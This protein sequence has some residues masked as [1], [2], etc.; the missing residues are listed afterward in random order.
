VWDYPRPPRLEASARH[1]LIRHRGEVVAETRAALRVLETSHPPTYYIPREDVRAVL[2]PRLDV[3]THCEWK[4]RAAYYDV[5]IAGET[6]RACA[7]SYPDPVPAFAE[8]RG[9]LAFYAQPFEGCFVDG[10]RVDSQTGRFYGGWI[11]ADVVGPFKGGAGTAG[12]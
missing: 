11:T 9:H 8:L 3:Q 5:E 12:W 7:W 2:H 1:L 10:E 4:G 6:I